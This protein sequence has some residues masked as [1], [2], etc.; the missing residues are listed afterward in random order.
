MGDLT[1]FQDKT[2]KL[3]SNKCIVFEVVGSVSQNLKGK[4][5][6]HPK[7]LHSIH[8][9]EMCKH[10][11]TKRCSYRGLLGPGGFDNLRGDDIS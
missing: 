10:V 5:T 6:S 3:R 4:K 7:I 1:C 9:K 11:Q 2:G 8:V